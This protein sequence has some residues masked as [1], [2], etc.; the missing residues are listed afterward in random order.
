MSTAGRRRIL[1]ISGVA[2]LALG[3]VAL[4]RPAVAAVPEA[5]PLLLSETGLYAP[6][7]SIDPANRPFS[8]QYPLWTDGATK[9]RWVRL[10]AGASIDA[11][12]MDAWRFAAGTVFWKEF[13]WQGR[14]VETRVIRIQADGSAA[15][16]T[17][18]WNAARTEARLAP[19]RGVAR[20]HEVARDK[21][22]TIPA[23]A[24]CGNCH[25][26]GPSRIL[27]FSALQLSDDRDPLAPHA[28]P[29][30]AAALTLRTLVAERRLRTGIGASTAL[31]PRITARDSVERAA[32]G[33]LSSNC[34]S[35]HNAAGPLARLG[36]SL[37]PDVTYWSSGHSRHGQLGP[38]I[39]AT[40]RHRGRFPLPG[41]TTGARLIEPGE[42]EASAVIN[43]MRSRRPATQMPPLGTVLVDSAGVALVRRW[44]AGMH[45]ATSERSAPPPIR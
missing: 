18:R 6:D 25:E 40:L 23:T 37:R 39:A 27:G 29:L 21:W 31:S 35:C 9:R 22:H 11:R 42:P 4:R 14:P 19:E 45:A 7:G 41:D 36:F 8:P 43:R 33:Y 34:G 26:S 17:Y 3:V 44:I 16:A 5:F 38:A 24:D 30:P 15:Y 20:G 12:D 2:A 10:P 28:E 13:A 32:L 1:A